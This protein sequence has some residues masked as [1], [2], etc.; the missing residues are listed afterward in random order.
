VIV[1]KKTEVSKRA[2]ITER[3]ALDAAQALFPALCLGTGHRVL[4]RTGRESK[5]P[6]EVVFYVEWDEPEG[7]ADGKGKG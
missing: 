2:G 6:G 4:D 5:H 7:A 3:D 1:S